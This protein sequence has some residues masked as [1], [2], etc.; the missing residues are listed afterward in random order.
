MR[1]VNRDELIWQITQALRTLPAQVRADI[2][3]NM[4]DR[5][6]MAD[7]RLAAHVAGRGLHRFEV[8]TSAPEG[9]PCPVLREKQGG[10]IAGFED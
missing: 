2:A 5:R 10:G 3:C 6:R 9:P 1:Q 8:L 4:P 7:S